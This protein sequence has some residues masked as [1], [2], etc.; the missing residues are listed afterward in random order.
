VVF[1]RRETLNTLENASVC[2]VIQWFEDLVR[3]ESTSGSAL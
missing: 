1:N 3:F 2:E